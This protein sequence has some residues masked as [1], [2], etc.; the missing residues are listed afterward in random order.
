MTGARRR[1]MAHGGSQAGRRL[2]QARQF[3]NLY[4]FARSKIDVVLRPARQPCGTCCGSTDCGRF[5]A[6]TRVRCSQGARQPSC[7]PGDAGR[8]REPSSLGSLPIPASG[9]GASAPRTEVVAMIEPPE[10]WRSFPL[11]PSDVAMVLDHPVFSAQQEDD[12]EIGRRAGAELLHPYWEPDLISFLYR[13]PPELLLQGGLE[14]G[15]VRSRSPA[16]FRTSASSDSGRSCR[17]TTTTQLSGARVRRAPPA[18]RLSSARR[19]RNRRRSTDR[20]RELRASRAPTFASLHR[21]WDLLNLE[22]WVRQYVGETPRVVQCAVQFSP[23][24]EE[25]TLPKS[26]IASRSKSGSRCA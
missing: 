9:R 4:R 21:A 22:T 18:R 17:S 13:V 10:G 15:L 25:E 2:H 14:K 23:K 19:A 16:V 24:G 8:S 3:G 1:R 12:Y 6:S 7:R 20:H 5:S 26:R 11:L